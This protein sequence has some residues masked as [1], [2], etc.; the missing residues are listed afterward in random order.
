MDVCISGVENG[1]VGYVLTCS[2]QFI[3]DDYH[4]FAAWTL[5][6]R[7]CDVTKAVFG[8]TDDE[9]TVVSLKAEASLQLELI[10]QR[11]HIWRT[12]NVL[13]VLNLVGLDIAIITYLRDVL[14]NIDTIF[15]V[16][17]DSKILV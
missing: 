16:F 2:C 1:L 10:I 9:D 6:I 8:A 12:D 15:N 4:N 11:L 3:G 17:E 7:V 14:S 13:S 5:G